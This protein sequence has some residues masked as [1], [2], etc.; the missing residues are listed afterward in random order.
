MES[1]DEL[2]QAMNDV[3]RKIGRNLLLFQQMETILKFLI[4]QR[5]I[6]APISQLKTVVEHQTKAVSNKTLGY[7]LGVFLNDIYT[8]Q[9]T[10]QEE[11]NQEEQYQKPAEIMVSYSFSLEAETNDPSYLQ[12]RKD[13]LAEVLRQRNDL[14]HHLYPR[15]NQASIESWREVESYLDQQKEKVLPE[16]E[17]LQQVVT[18]FV[19]IAKAGLEA[20]ISEI[21]KDQAQKLEI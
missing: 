5:K 21:E 4:A 19:E 20:L 7:A 16:V 8:L 12:S 14:V 13:S 17:Y 3:C 11:Q 1:Q 15:I 2:K 18:N 6:S 10:D 9:I